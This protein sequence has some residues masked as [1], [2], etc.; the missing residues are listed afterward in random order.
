MKT[1]NF[2]L[3]VVVVGLFLGG[4]G[5]RY[6]PYGYFNGG[7]SEVLTTKD[8]FMVNFRGNSFT[9]EDT[10]MKYALRRAS[11]LAIMNGYQY[12]IVLSSKD[13]TVTTKYENT[14]NNLKQRHGQKKDSSSFETA[15]STS[16]TMGETRA[17]G[18]SLAIKCFHSAPKEGEVID[19]IYFLQ[20]NE[21]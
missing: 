9:K 16:K 19:A 15:I 17:P 12:F 7:Y 11:E 5:S 8:S 4:C 6:Q 18:V 14:S 20:Q 10:V 21:D 13:V 3:A 1:K 2:K